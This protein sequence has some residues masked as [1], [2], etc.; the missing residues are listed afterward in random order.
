MAT[1]IETIDRASWCMRGAPDNI[2]M[3]IDLLQEHDLPKRPLRICGVLES[4]VTL[5]QSDHLSTFLVDG[6]PYYPVGSL[7]Q[8]LHHIVLPQ[9][10][11]IDLLTHLFSC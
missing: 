7:A 3:V 10:V 6:L 4:I 9:H 11:P 2:F 5:F 8:L 1:Q